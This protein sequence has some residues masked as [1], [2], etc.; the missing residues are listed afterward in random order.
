M[1]NLYDP[2][3]LESVTKEGRRIMV[4]VMTSLDET[5]SGG[6]KLGQML[7]LYSKG[8]SGKSLLRELIQ[9]QLSNEND[10]GQ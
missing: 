2:Q 3:V 8:N 10:D 6:G 1:N 9:K 4:D 7:V 5:L